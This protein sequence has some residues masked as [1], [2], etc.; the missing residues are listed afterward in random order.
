MSTTR[1]AILKVAV[2][3][4][5]ASNASMFLGTSAYM[6]IPV[7]LV[8]ILKSVTLVEVMVIGWLM[9]TEEPS[10][11]LATAVCTIVVGISCSVGYGGT[12]GG[13]Q[14]LGTFA[15]G[16]F[17]MLLASSSEAIK[18]VLSQVSIERLAFF[19]SIYWCSPV[20]TAIGFALSAAL[21][22][23]TMLGS[24]EWTPRLLLAL[25]SSFVLGGIVS[26][27]GFWLTKLVG[28]LAM[29]VLVNARNV[30]FVLFSVVA[31][32]EEC[33]AAQYVGYPV[34]LPRVSATVA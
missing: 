18:S 30:G 7:P 17:I 20:M 1:G 28:G 3:L 23:P 25:A 8:Q 5:I 4:S 31:F 32:G 27:A 2:P 24:T 33:T 13:S 21:E 14:G 19:D 34:A 16:V 12:A 22:L 9:G 29:K 10:A 11:L 6:Y 15:Y 26:F